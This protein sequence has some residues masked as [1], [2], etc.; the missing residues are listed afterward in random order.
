MFILWI[1]NKSIKIISHTIKPLSNFILR[2]I[3]C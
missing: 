3:F 2:A 1:F